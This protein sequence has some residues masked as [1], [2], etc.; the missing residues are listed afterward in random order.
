MTE[1]GDDFDDELTGDAVEQFLARK[2][3]EAREFETL[4]REAWASAQRASERV[5]ELK[6]QARG[7][8]ED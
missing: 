5:R 8:T 4:A 3:Q 2:L 6:A 1:H 7:D